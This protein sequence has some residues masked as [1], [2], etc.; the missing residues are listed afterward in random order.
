[1]SDYG[2]TACSPL[3]NLELSLG[4]NRIAEN[5]GLSIVSLT[6]RPDCDGLDDKLLSEFAVALPEVG[7]VQ[8]HGDSLAII[9]LQPNQYF[10]ISS[11]SWSDPVAHVALSIGDYVYLTDQSDSWA[12]LS[13][14]GPMRYA[15]LERLCPVDI[16][17]AIFD[18]TRAV[19]TSMEHLS[20]IIEM[21]ADEQFR[22]F[23]PRSSAQSFSQ[24]LIT[25]LQHVCEQP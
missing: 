20:V 2:L 19:R 9:G 6:P 3:G 13:I 18:K 10:M 5:A 14:S 15:A 17:P 21:P 4:D 1:M 25:S 8:R 23:T 12:V 24:A 7:Y 22:L 16:A 11:E